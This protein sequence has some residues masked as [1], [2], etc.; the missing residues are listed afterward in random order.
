MTCL[1]LDLISGR[2]KPMVCESAWIRLLC[3]S[4]TH[5]SATG[6]LLFQ[7]M[8]YTNASLQ[9]HL[10]LPVHALGQIREHWTKEFFKVLC[11]SCVHSGQQTNSR[12]VTKWTNVQSKL[13]HHTLRNLC[14]IYQ[15]LPLCCS[16]TTN[17]IGNAVPPRA[18]LYAAPS[19]HVHI[20]SKRLVP[21]V[22][23]SFV[24][25][26][27]ELCKTVSGISLLETIYWCPLEKEVR[28]QKS[29]STPRRKQ[30]KTKQRSE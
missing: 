20:W 25:W 26:C 5:T 17:S 8:P 1:N 4:Y 16:P 6:L 14:F 13:C 27:T 28:R 15:V 29:Q 19:F 24:C 7:S 30:N 2:N 22:I 18:C 21:V 3:I 12:Q 10:M 11:H 23:V 9:G